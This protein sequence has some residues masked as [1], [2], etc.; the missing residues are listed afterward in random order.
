MSD[1]D[2]SFHIA[3]HNVT[4]FKG[5]V[6]SRTC[7]YKFARKC[8]ER[9][10]HNPLGLMDCFGRKHCQRMR[11]RRVVACTDLICYIKQVC[12]YPDDV[13]SFKYALKI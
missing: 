7:Q 12:T 5:L 1:E 11:G 9:Q 4:T 6:S 3:N 13:K 2:A 10:V 8:T